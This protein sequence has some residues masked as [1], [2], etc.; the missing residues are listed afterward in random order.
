[1]TLVIVSG[2]L[3]QVSSLCVFLLPEVTTV[4]SLSLNR[5]SRRPAIK[6]GELCSWR[7]FAQTHTKLPDTWLVPVGFRN[8][9]FKGAL[10]PASPSCQAVRESPARSR[11]GPVSFWHV[12][13]LRGL[14]Q[15]EA[16]SPSP[17]LPAV[18]LGKVESQEE[19]DRSGNPDQEPVGTS[20]R[21]QLDEM[22]CAPSLSATR[23]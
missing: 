16:K 7:V 17:F 5:V 19:P 12:V 14:L 23:V 10:F 18:S 13:S 20:D 9:S 6:S 3:L 11:R 2:E 4:V 8:G 15:L 21:T 1:M 22:Q